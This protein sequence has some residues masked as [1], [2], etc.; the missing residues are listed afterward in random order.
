MKKVFVLGDSISIH[1]GPFWEAYIQ[2]VFSYDRKGKNQ[3]CRDLNI[4]S[5]VN[6]GDSSNVLE[7]LQLLPDLEY[8]VLLLNCGLHDIKTCEGDRQVSEK[9]YEK[10]LNE[11]VELVL[12]RGKKVVWVNSTPVNDQQHNHICTIFSRY[13]EDLIRYNEIAAK[14]MAAKEIPVIDLYRFTNN[15]E[16]PLHEDHVHFYEAIRKLQAAYITGSL[17]ALE[18]SGRL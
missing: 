5:Q 2:G 16:M 4:V 9:D 13:N 7:Y 17:M 18:Q 15:L 1:Y 3:E 14:V 6:G 11:I 8:D 12:N 10:N